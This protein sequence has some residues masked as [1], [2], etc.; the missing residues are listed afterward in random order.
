M[1][2]SFHDL[3][4][5]EAIALGITAARLGVGHVDQN[6]LKRARVVRRINTIATA[7]VV[8]AASTGQSVVPGPADQRV[9]ASPAGQPVGR[10]VA[11][12][13]VGVIGADPP[14]MPTETT[15]RWAGRTY[16]IWRAQ[17]YAMP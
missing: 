7:Q 2:T 15:V 12:K 14:A 9:I 1:E 5:A 17:S 16:G 3:D 13:L 6:A 10:A 8:R 11:F 4:A